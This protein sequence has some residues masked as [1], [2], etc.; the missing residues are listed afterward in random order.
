M[1]PIDSKFGK[2]SRK[3]YLQFPASGHLE[4]KDKRKDLFKFYDQR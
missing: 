2:A 4:I 3:I 1:N